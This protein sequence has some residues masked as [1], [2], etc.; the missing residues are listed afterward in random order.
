MY[1]FSELLT[2]ARSGAKYKMK[3]KTTDKPPSGFEAIVG[4]KSGGYR[5]KFGGQWRY[6][7]PWKYSSRVAQ[8]GEYIGS[9]AH[10]HVGSEYAISTEKNGEKVETHLEVIEMEGD[11]V[12]VKNSET[13]INN[14]LTLYNDYPLE[15]L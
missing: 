3:Y 11:R 13:E 2:K 5:K 14:W 10:M 8:H 15:S 1:S 12:R 7:Y 9:E 6:W 4:S